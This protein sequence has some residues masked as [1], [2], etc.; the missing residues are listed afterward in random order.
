MVKKKKK[1][2]FDSPDLENRSNQLCHKSML[3]I[4]GTHTKSSN[5]SRNKNYTT[6]QMTALKKSLLS[7][8]KPIDFKQDLQPF[9]WM[10]AASFDEFAF[11][12]I[13]S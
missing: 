11:L 13:T 6:E 1:T 10:Q 3:G 5:K 7:L 12:T 9:R 8:S 4:Q 2:V